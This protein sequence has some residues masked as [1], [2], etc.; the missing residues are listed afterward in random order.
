MHWMNPA[1]FT[2][3]YNNLSVTRLERVW[4]CC[5]CPLLWWDI[6]PIEVTTLDINP[7]IFI[8]QPNLQE[9]EL[10]SCIRF[11][12][13][14]RD[15]SSWFFQGNNLLL[16]LNLSETMEMWQS[17]FVQLKIFMQHF[18]NFPLVGMAFL[19][20]VTC[21]SWPDSLKHIHLL[22]HTHNIIMLLSTHFWECQNVS[23]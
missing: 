5:V 9:L 22:L 4:L 20:L 19:L 21:I 6:G 17:W 3:H 16:L 10:D 1:L 18:A 14:F 12:S 8:W 11:F 2:A 13:H 7:D 15:V 23:K